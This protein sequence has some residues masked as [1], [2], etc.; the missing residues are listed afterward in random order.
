MTILSS[1]AGK[2]LMSLAFFLT[3]SGAQHSVFA[4]TERLVIESGDNAMS[5]ETARE[6]KEQ[7]DTT[8][9]LRNKINKRAEKEFDKRDSALDA[10]DS[11]NQSIN[12]NAYW[13]PDTRRCLDRKTGRQIIP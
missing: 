13:E 7:W 10:I 6:H 3:L 8:R 2:A 5:K 12:V 1:R 4:A 11:C 9:S